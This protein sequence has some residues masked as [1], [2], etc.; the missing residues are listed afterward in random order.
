VRGRGCDL[1]SDNERSFG[2]RLRRA[3]PKAG[4]G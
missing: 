3:V 4:F 2:G 1:G